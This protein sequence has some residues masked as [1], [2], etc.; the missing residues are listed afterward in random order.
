MPDIQCWQNGHEHTTA[1]P[2]INILNILQVIVTTKIIMITGKT[3]IYA[4]QYLI[5]LRANENGTSPLG[6]QDEKFILVS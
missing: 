3:G 4:E 1:Q 6:I 2:E 5:I